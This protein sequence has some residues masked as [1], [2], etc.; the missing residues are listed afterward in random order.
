MATHR[1]VRW[2]MALALAGLQA[3]AQSP[4][5]PAAELR[6]TEWT[7]LELDG[8][9]PPLPAA[10]SAAVRLTLQAEGARVVGHAGCNR[11]SGGYALDGAALRFTPLA[12]TRMAC[13]PEAMDLERRVLAMLGAVGGWRVDGDQLVLLAGDRV[14]ARFG[15]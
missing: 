14:L 15:R 9:A 1:P 12:A 2:C 3:C 10:P 5:L 11:F 8:R 13:E 4:A 7:L 6:G